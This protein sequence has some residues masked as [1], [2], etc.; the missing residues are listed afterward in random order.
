[1]ERIECYLMREIISREDR[2]KAEEM[3]QLFFQSQELSLTPPIDIFALAT[4][5]GF[6]VR[7]A[8]F[9][10]EIDGVMLANEKAEKIEN[11]L[12]NKVIVYSKKK[13]PQETRFIVAH[14]LGHYIKEKSANPNGQ[15]LAAARDHSEA[16]YSN[17]KDE[18]FIDYMA[19]AI[20]VPKEDLVKRFSRLQSTGDPMLY[21]KIA[22]V[23]K[24]NEDL[25]KRR[26][27]EVFL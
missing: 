18:Q 13:S 17:N 3:I 12:S 23:Y 14:E 21:K 8:Y 7:G 19:A 20:L 1:M 6:D 11:F 4:S 5:V 2:D 10:S 27:E 16:D 26:V 25:A 9:S 24:V 15:I 22:K